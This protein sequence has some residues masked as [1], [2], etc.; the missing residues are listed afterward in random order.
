MARLRRAFGTLVVIAAISLLVSGVLSWLS[1]PRLPKQFVVELSLAGSI[2]ETP[3]ALSLGFLEAQRLSVVEIASGLRATIGDKRV[4]GVLVRA[5]SLQTGWAAAREIG[6]ALEEIRR[7]GIPV[8]ALLEAGGDKEY[9]VASAADSVFLV[10]AG[11]LLVDGIAASVGFWKG[12]M[13]KVGLEADMIRVGAYKSAPETY[14]RTGMSQEFRESFDALLDDVFATYVGD[15]ARGRDATEAQTRS[16]IDEGPYGA[17][18]ALQ[19]SLIDGLRYRAQILEHMGVGEDEAV[20]L[21]RYL[22]ER[23]KPRGTRV[24]YVVV[25]GGIMPGRS[26]DLPFSEPT[27]GCESIALALREAREDDSLKG[28]LLR[29]NSPGGSAMASDVIWDEM[30]RTVE[31]KPVVVSMGDVA[32]SGGYYVAMPASRIVAEAT[33]ITGSIGVYAGKVVAQELYE[34]A[35]YH[36]EVL[37]RGMHADLFSETRPFTDDERVALQDMLW[38]FYWNAFITKAAQGRGMSPEQVDI[39]GRGRVWSG[40]RAHSVG[41]VDTLG[42]IW[43]A[44]M[45]MATLLGLPADAD[46]ALVPVPK[47]KPLLTRIAEMLF[48]ADGGVRWLARIAEP[49]GIP[50][51]PGLLL[52]LPC[53]LIIE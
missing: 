36:V 2:R 7:H 49:A 53:R 52:R 45:E 41:L 18:A 34:K 11:H 37:T 23:G 5:S 40:L 4:R 25:E 1:R 14:T 12:T 10:P 44:Q 17:D 35:G 38:D 33:T 29:V 50:T 39:V 26:T 30:R 13:D 31:V 27:A 16:R 28:V 8:M 15:I 46:M 43:E 20:E 3:G 51:E 6:R 24:A 22:K 21:G 42:G 47:P 32:A 48:Q 9:V 19:E